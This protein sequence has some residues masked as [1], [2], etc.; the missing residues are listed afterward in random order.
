MGIILMPGKK[1]KST[2]TGSN[3]YNEQK[4]KNE[5][6]IKIQNLKNREKVL[7]GTWEKSII[8]PG[9][10]TRPNAYFTGKQKTMLND[11]T[12]VCSQPKSREWGHATTQASGFFQQTKWKENKEMEGEQRE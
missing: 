11:T 2:D 4:M 12:S 9:M 5:T 7:K 3:A 8:Y 6:L 1:H 10:I